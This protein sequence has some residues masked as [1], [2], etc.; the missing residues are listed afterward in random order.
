MSATDNPTVPTVP[1]VEV[2]NTQLARLAG[3]GVILGSRHV[4]MNPNTLFSGE[5]D[6]AQLLAAFGVEIADQTGP[7]IQ[8]LVGVAELKVAG[9]ATV[10]GV[11]V[12]NTPIGTVFTDRPI[13]RAGKDEATVLVA[14]LN[15]PNTDVTAVVTFGGSRIRQKVVSLDQY[16]TGFFTMPVSRVGVHT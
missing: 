8:S 5:S 16:G 15:R 11:T 3:A 12:E 6:L 1:T 4:F 10:H 14:V 9:S 2:T 7:R 13:Y